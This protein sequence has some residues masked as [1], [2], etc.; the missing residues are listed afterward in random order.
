M[1]I[2]PSLSP[3][4]HQYGKLVHAAQLAWPLPDDWGDDHI[5]TRP[6]RPAPTGPT[7]RSAHLPDFAALQQQL[8]AHKNLTLQLLW[9]EYRHAH[10]DG[11]SYS[12][13]QPKQL[14]VRT[15]GT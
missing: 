13:I 6:P 2:D 14:R 7:Q 9:Q 8:A 10:P 12:R 1:R 5:T 15:A 11:C 4:V 3:P